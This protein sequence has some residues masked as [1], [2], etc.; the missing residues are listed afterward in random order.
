MMSDKK[1]VVV[2]A[3]ALGSHLVLL[4]RNCGAQMTVVDFD[5]VESKNVMSQMHSRQSVRKNKAVVLSQLANFLFSFP[6]KP[7]PSRLGESNCAEI[8]GGADLVVDCVDN[9]E[10]REIIQKFCR[11]ESLPCLH[12]ALAADG[13]FGR[14]VWDQAF[15]IDYESA[16]GA[17]TCEDGEHLPFISVVSSYLASAVQIWLRTDIMRGFEVRPTG[18]VDTVVRDA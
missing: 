16:D 1:I 13:A 15:K 5:R 4:L 7:V 11:R 10:T 8:L 14:V 17:P 3:G 18:A 9:G 2:G 6:V 12:G